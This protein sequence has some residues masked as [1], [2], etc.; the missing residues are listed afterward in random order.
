MT[1][2]VIAPYA[3]TPPPATHV[4]NETNS[5]AQTPYTS[6]YTQRQARSY[7]LLDGGTTAEVPWPMH[8]G[9]CTMAHAPRPMHHSRS[10]MADRTMPM[11]RYQCTMADARCR[12]PVY[13]MTT[14]CVSG[15]SCQCPASRL[16]RSAPW[17]MPVN[18]DRLRDA[19]LALL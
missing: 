19:Q 4:F 2:H 16:Y 6:H 14:S 5:M 17:P 13:R 9:R 12:R 11:H 1:G 15:K 3:L 18:Q 7:D 10:A 8:H